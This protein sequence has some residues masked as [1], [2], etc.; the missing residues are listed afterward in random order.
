MTEKL[1]C[2]QCDAASYTNFQHYQ[3]KSKEHAPIVRIVTNDGAYSN[4]DA[5][6]SQNPTKNGDIKEMDY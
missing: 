4:Y 5:I 6:T 1:T 2:N 3:H